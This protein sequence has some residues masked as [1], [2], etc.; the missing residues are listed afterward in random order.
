MGARRRSGGGDACPAPQPDLSAGGRSAGRRARDRLAGGC[1]GGTP[2]TSWRRFRRTAR[3]RFLRRAAPHLHPG[4][5]LV[6]AAK[7][8]EDGTLLRMSEVMAQEAGNGRAGHR[9][10]RTELRRGGGP[11]ARRRRV[12]V[13][14]AGAEAVAAVQHDFRSESFR[15]YASDDVVGVENRRRAEERHRH[16]RRRRR[17]ARARAQRPLRAGDPRSGGDFPAG[18]LARWPTRHPGRAERAGRSRV[19]LHRRTQPQSGGSG[20]SS[21]RGVRS[22]DVLD[23]MRM[24]AEGGP[25]HASGAG[26]SGA[27]QGVELPHCGAD[28][29]RA[30][31]P[32]DAAGGR[33][34][35]DAAPPAVR[36]RRVMG[37]F[38]STARRAAAH[39]APLGRAAGKPCPPRR[40]HVAA[41]LRTAPPWT[42]SRSC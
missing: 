9:A 42:R 2:C 18:L 23:G 35:S 31:R 37:L 5:T 12:L 22:R 4:A 25:N 28:G 17:V 41:A 33:G 20:S 38:G 30:R 36:A 29:R 6:S 14:G 39:G 34:G 15:V 27:R 10:L 24:V 26:F 19:D 1:V 13:A 11:G 40:R 8:I 21:A 32:Q 16:R 3:A 7:G